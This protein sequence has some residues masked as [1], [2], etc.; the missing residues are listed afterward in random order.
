MKAAYLALSLTLVMT[1]S[2]IFS[3]PALAAP[4]AL[5]VA[6]GVGNTAQAKEPIEKFLRHLEKT[7]GIKAGSMTSEYHT[8]LQG[9]L[10]YFEQAKPH[11]AVVDLGTYLSQRAA[12]KLTPLAHM[13]GL[14]TKRYHVMVRK[15][16]FKKLDE[17]KGKSFYISEADA[18]FA[19]QVILG[20][21]LDLTKDVTL[22]VKKPAKC[23][24]SVGRGKK[25]KF[26]ADAALVDE[27]T[28]KR[29]KEISGLVELESIFSSPGLPGLTLV[30][31]DSRASRDLV[32]KIRKA[33]PK[34]CAGAGKEL[35]KQFQMASFKAANPA[36]YKKLEKA[37]GM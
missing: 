21:K 4:L 13:G 15:G 26:K 7:V 19:S 5:C 25:G 6:N 22:K 29:R 10:K 30:V 24:K 20:G 35:C 36:D 11:M 34:L 33:L 37:Y 31:V 14:D 28:F 18:R 2:L 23:L 16:A 32:D 3:S 1:G 12:Q 27:M 17:L 8:Q 9:C